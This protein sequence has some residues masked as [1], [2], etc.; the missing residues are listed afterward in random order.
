MQAVTRLRATGTPA[1]IYALEPES[2]LLRTGTGR[3]AAAECLYL[4]NVGLVEMRLACPRG[5]MMD[6]SS[7]RNPV[8]P[9]AYLQHPM[10]P[11]PPM[12]PL[13][14]HILVELVRSDGEH[15]F[16]SRFRSLKA[17]KQVAE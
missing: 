11:I 8:V 2:S 13:G 14:S 12:P 4:Q 6:V 3:I 15:A 5:L 1:H 9:G 16:G 17:N 10:P 7:A